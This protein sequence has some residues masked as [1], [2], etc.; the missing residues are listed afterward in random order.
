MIR[1]C[2]SNPTTHLRHGKNDAFC[3]VW[4]PFHGYP[5]IF[6]GYVNLYENGVKILVYY[7]HMLHGA[8]IFTNIYPKNH[9]NVGKYS[10]HGASGIVSSLHHPMVWQYSSSN[11]V[12]IVEAGCGSKLCT[13]PWVQVA[14]HCSLPRIPFNCWILSGRWHILRCLTD[15]FSGFIFKKLPASLAKKCMLN[16]MFLIHHLPKNDQSPVAIRHQ[17]THS[18]FI[19][20]GLWTIPVFL[21]ETIQMG[22]IFK[23]KLL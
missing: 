22:H 15:M 13:G 19:V 2:W 7:T 11:P 16:Q 14:L 20:F 1:L 4:Y 9:P 8:G 5:N 12:R 23:S 18:T 17:L 3:R 10:I 21:W 6:N